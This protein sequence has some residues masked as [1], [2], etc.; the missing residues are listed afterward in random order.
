M[1]AVRHGTG[2]ETGCEVSLN[3]LIASYTSDLRDI[4]EPAIRHDVRLELEHGFTGFLASSETALTPDEYVRFVEIAADEARGR[5]LVIHHASFNT[6]DENIEL[7]RQAA[8]AGAELALLAYPPSFYPNSQ[9]DIYEYT[10]AFCDGVDIAVMLFPVPL[11]GF[12]RLHPASL[13]IEIMERLIEDCPNIVAGESRRREP[14]HRRLRRDLATAERARRR[15]RAVGVGRDAARNAGAAAVQRDV[16]PGVL[17]VHCAPD[18]PAHSTQRVLGGDGSLL[19][20]GSRSQ[21]EWEDRRFRRNEHG[22]Q[23]RVEIPG[24]AQWIQRRADSHAHP[25]A[26]LRPDGDATERLDREVDFPRPTSLT[27]PSSSDAIPDKDV[28]S[29][30]SPITRWQGI[31]PALV[32]ET[33]TAASVADHGERVQEGLVLVRQRS[34]APSQPHAPVVRKPML[35]VSSGISEADTGSASSSSVGELIRWAIARSAS[36]SRP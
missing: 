26:S 6:L 18:L 8:G 9:T 33:V 19:D 1:T 35:M 23:D 21:G 17:R 2:P 29:G 10:R 34:G 4:N 5:A 32:D 24:L 13:S 36:T 15:E 7:A 14:R 12:E 20:D 3:T 31:P 28:R 11:W 25:S 27:K 22:A 30:R 16:Q